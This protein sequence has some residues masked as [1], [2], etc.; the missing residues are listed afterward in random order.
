M[1]RRRTPLR[2]TRFARSSHKSKYRL[3]VRHLDYMAFVRRL[4]CSARH[5]GP[6]SGKVEADHVGIPMCSFHHKC[7]HGFAG[8][9][10]DFDQAQMRLFVAKALV[11]T[12]LAARELGVTNLSQAI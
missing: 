11:A 6:C 5:L 9:F 1:L 8:V 2:R 7:R 12:Q 10:R 3:R 4:G